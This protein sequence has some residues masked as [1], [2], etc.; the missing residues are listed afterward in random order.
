VLC[1][2]IAADEPSLDPADVA[3]RIT[4]R[5]K[6]VIAVHL[7]GY[8]ARVERLRELCDERDLVLIEDCAQGDG[9]S[10]NGGRMAGTVGDAGCFSFFAKTQLGVGEG[11]ALVTGDAELADRVRSLRSHAMTSVTWDRHRGHAE[12]YDVVDL[13]F[14]Y[15]IDEMRATLAHRRLLRLTESVA[16]LRAIAARYRDLLADVDGVELCFTPDGVARSAHFA[17][18][19]LLADAG[20]RDAVRDR[21]HER[22]I[23]T[24]F[25]P[26]L[27]RVSEYSSATGADSVPRAEEF[28]DRHC[29]LPMFPTLTAERQQLV[30]DELRSAL[31]Q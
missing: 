30:V 2:S 18:P 3:K 10:I 4:P 5:T 26:A 31:L 15:R 19:I 22:G 29:C 20:T 28:A 1:D 25:Y 9:G 12:T 14:N 8:P 27:S 24:T 16:A 6:A 17:F 23:Q 7:C 11:G 21:V 13:G